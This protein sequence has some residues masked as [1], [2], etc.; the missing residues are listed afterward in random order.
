VWCPEKKR[1]KK[2]TLKQ[3]GIIDPECGFI[4]TGI[5]RKGRI[6]KANTR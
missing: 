6:P 2:V 4:P 1:T 5:S 3:L